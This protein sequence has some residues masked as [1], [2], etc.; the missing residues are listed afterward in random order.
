MT[1]QGFVL[2]RQQTLHD[3]AVASANGVIQ[4]TPGFA[5]AILQIEGIV[6]DIVT[7][8]VTIDGSTWYGTYAENKT[9][10]I[11]RRNATVDG[12]YSVP[13]NGVN[14]FRARLTRVG[15]TVTVIS[16]LITAVHSLPKIVVEEASVSASPSA[17]A[18]ASESASASASESAS[19]S[20]SESASESASTSESTST[21]ASESAS[22]SESASESASESSSTSESASTSASDSTSESASVSVSPSA[23]TSASESVSESTSE[24]ASE[25]AS[26]STSESASESASWSL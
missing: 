11:W 19:S 14:Q 23:S 24:S 7:F 16:V 4:S 15:G 3:A 6:G 17:S 12:I 21:S 2:N 22:T 10:G 8:E 5:F 25:S 1:N 13:I 9:T 18:S 20:T 26:P